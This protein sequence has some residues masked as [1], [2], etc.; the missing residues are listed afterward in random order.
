MSKVLPISILLLSFVVCGCSSYK[1][2]SYTGGTLAIEGSGVSKQESR[3]VASFDRI[4]LDSIIDVSVSFG[5]N[6]GIIVTADDNLLPI[7][8]TDVSEQQLIIDC[9][10]SLT[11]NLELKAEIVMPPG[12]LVACSLD[13]TGDLIIEGYSG[14]QLVL[15]SDGVGDITVSGSVDQVHVFVES[16][17]DVDLSALQARQA[18]VYNDSVG[19][20]T[21]NAS[22]LVDGS[23][24]SVGDLIILGDPKEVRATENSVGDIIRK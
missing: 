9:T 23:V 21:V 14:D 19:D 8:R 10:S 20:A 22:E 13:S 2:V 18:F 4:R 11:T 15:K 1:A 7:I 3:S 5:D 17:G 24:S 12:V 16:T 6:P